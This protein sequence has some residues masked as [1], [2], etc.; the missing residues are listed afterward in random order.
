MYGYQAGNAII[1][2][3]DTGTGLEEYAESWKHSFEYND[4]EEIKAAT[5][6]FGLHVLKDDELDYF[7]SLTKDDDIKG[8]V[9]EFSDPQTVREA[10]SSHLEQIKRERPELGAKLEAFQNVSVESALQV[11]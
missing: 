2:Y 3:L 6:A 11:E 8:F 4:P 5:Q 9:N 7:F 10:I 1:K